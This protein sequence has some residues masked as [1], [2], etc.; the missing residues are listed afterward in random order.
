[1]KKTCLPLLLSALLL[2][3]CGEGGT[4]IQENPSSS[5][6][7]SES[8]LS[9]EDKTSSSEESGSGDL[10]SQITADITWT[11]DSLSAFKMTTYDEVETSYTIGGMDVEVYRFTK[12]NKKKTNVIQFANGNDAGYVRNSVAVPGLTS[13]ILDQLDQEEYT[14][15][16][17]VYAGSSAADLS[18]IE[19][20]S[21]VY[22]CNG[23]QF[24]KII[25]ESTY[26]CYFKSIVFDFAA[27]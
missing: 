4:S 20:A 14:G 12:N 2:A 25:N 16:I 26:G 11:F 27:F 23:A 22:A 21:G 10:Q 9:S 5:E 17:S 13:I 1:M 19:G 6:N 18:A 7:T 3:A 24:F 8:S 15:T